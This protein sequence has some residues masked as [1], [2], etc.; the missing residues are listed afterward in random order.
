MHMDDKE[1][2]EKEGAAG[3]AAAGAA[4]PP[5]PLLDDSWADA[6]RGP[7]SSTASGKGKDKSTGKGG[8]ADGLVESSGLP[9]APTA[10][11]AL[12]PPRR[13]GPAGLRVGDR[14]R[15]RDGRRGTLHDDVEEDGCVLVLVGSGRRATVWPVAVQDIEP[16]AAPGPLRPGGGG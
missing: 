5:S 15:L 2:E 11:R 13:P 8:S 10:L 9:S 12:E 16:E 6:L 1:R 3:A 7:P 4:A 14:V